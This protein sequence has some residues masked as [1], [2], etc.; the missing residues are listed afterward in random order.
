MYECSSWTQ[1]ERV[2]R[3]ESPLFSKDGAPY[4]IASKE[5]N[6]LHILSLDTF[7]PVF[8]LLLKFIC[9]DFSDNGNISNY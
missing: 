3:V 6:D 9:N 7:P 5:K 8:N 2:S 4:D 1:K